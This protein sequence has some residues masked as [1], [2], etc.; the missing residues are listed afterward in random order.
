MFLC[1]DMC[2]G[3][4]F[5]PDNEIGA[6]EESIF[7]NFR[8]TIWDVQFSQTGAVF[9]GAGPDNAFRRENHGFQPDAFCKCIRTDPVAGIWEK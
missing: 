7:I 1:I 8:Y 3:A 4:F 5:A 6:A 2:A 9:E